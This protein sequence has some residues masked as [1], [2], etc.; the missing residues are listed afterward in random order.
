MTWDKGGNWALFFACF[1]LIEF[2]AMW[3]G[4]HTLSETFWDFLRAH[5]LWATVILWAGL[6]CLT[7]HFLAGW[8]Q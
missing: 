4:H 7:G 8:W 3:T 5:R 2:G 1:L 6:V